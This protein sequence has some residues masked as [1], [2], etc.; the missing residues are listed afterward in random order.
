MYID[1]QKNITLS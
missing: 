1:T